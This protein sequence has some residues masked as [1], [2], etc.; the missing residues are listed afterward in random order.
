M[1]KLRLYI[2]TSVIGGCFDAEFSEYSNKLFDEIIIGKKTAV[3]SDVVF[4]E[5]AG[6]SEKIQNVLKKI[7]EENI[8]VIQRNKEAQDLSLQYINAKAISPKFS[9]DALHIA[10]AT[11]NN[12][13]LLVSWNFKHIVNYN[14]ILKYNAI[15]LLNGYKHLEIRSPKEVV[16]EEEII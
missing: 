10:I 11:I 13:D 16:D 9:D 1:N 12:V 6:A 3:V 8:Q 15:N 2:D 14:R 5:I 7:P 4:E